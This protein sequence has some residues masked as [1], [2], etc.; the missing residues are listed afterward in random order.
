MASLYGYDSVFEVD[1]VT[2]KKIHEVMLK[3]KYASLFTLRKNGEANMKVA[4][5]HLKEASRLG[6]ISWQ[7]LRERSANDADIFNPNY[8]DGNSFRIDSG[9]E[10]MEK[11]MSGKNLFRSDITGEVVSVDFPAF[12]MNPPKDLKA[13]FPIS[14]EGGDKHLS[15]VIK[16]AN[17]KTKSVKYRNY[18]YGRS[19]GWDL[20]AYQVVFPDLKNG[21]DVSTALRILNQSAGAFPAAENLNLFLLY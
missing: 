14:F 12:Y 3:P 15:K 11:M 5:Q 7:E 10:N 19:I 17:G 16:L 13:L 9:A 18:F 8:F 21:R 6:V 20:K 2:A 4:F 1:G